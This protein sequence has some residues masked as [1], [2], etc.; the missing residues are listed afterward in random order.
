MHQDVCKDLHGFQQGIEWNM[1]H[2]HLESFSKNHLLE[3]RPNTKLGDHGTLDAHS[4]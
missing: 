4:C 1:F 3:V 2:G